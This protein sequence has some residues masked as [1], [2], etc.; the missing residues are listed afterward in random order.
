MISVVVLAGFIL[1]VLGGVVVILVR[2]F[3]PGGHC[4]PVTAEWIDELSIERY[5]PMLRLLDSSDLEFLRSQPGYTP[6]MESNLRAQ[7]CTIF[8]G[9]LR[10]LHMDFRRV[11]MA[12]KLVMV[13]S[14]YDRPDLAS[15]LMH[16][17]VMF[18]SGLIA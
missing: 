3:G 1:A 7:R 17:Q 12:L 5:R 9:Y 2:A 14:H 11:C 6:K 13:Q 10:C 16:H 8:R 18:A 15:A 4:L